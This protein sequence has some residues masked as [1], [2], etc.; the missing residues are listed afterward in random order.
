MISSSNSIKTKLLD[1]KLQN[2]EN[3]KELDI[4]TFINSIEKTI[5][6]LKE[7]LTK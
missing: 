4:K 3:I 7:Q 5:A 1:A 2:I 6:A